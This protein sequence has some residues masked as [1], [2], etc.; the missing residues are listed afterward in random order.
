MS[1]YR[2]SNRSRVLPRPI[3]VTVASEFVK[4]G[5][6]SVISSCKSPSRTDARITTLEQQ[7]TD[8]EVRLNA[9]EEGAANS[10]FSN[11]WL[12][13][14]GI[15]IGGLVVDRRRKTQG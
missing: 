9:L 2:C 5:P 12:L 6:L 14:G 4:P 8:L 7:N 15:V 13:F 1:P 11:P 3:P 10:P